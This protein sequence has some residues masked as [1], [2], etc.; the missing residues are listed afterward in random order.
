[1]WCRFRIAGGKFVWGEL[2]AA[3]PARAAFAPAQLMACKFHPAE[4]DAG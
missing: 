1:M 4:F 2:A 3:S